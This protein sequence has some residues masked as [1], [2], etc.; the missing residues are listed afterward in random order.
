MQIPG[1]PVLA[2]P[3]A[4]RTAA[5]ASLPVSARVRF[6]LAQSSHSGTGRPGDTHTRARV[7]VR[8]AGEEPAR[9]QSVRIQWLVLLLVI[10]F[11]FSAGRDGWKVNTWQRRSGTQGEAGACDSVCLS[12]LPPSLPRCC[13]WTHV[14]H[15]VLD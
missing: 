7:G 2:K 8:L 11:L 12:S 5:P 10:H 6:A 3:E 4:C 9:G 14:A 13:V 1:R 15:A